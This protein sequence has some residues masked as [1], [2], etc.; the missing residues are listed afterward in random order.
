MDGSLRH[1]LVNFHGLVEGK[2]GSSMGGL[3]HKTIYG[4]TEVNTEMG[5]LVELK[6]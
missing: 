1:K 3:R 4:G 2:G 5:V 6:E